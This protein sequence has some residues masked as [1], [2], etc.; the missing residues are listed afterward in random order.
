MFYVLRLILY[1]IFI[2]K[3]LETDDG[4]IKYNPKDRDLSL[5]ITWFNIW[6]KLVICTMKR[7]VTTFF[8][9]FTIKIKISTLNVYTLNA[10]NLVLKTQEFFQVKN[11]ISQLI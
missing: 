2:T 1:Y 3:N 10:C 4:T 9:I 7:M 11:F 8:N 5:Y 6:F